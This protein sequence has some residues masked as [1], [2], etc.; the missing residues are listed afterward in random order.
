MVRATSFLFLSI[1]LFDI[2]CVLNVCTALDVGVYKPLPDAG[3]PAQT[4]LQG[5]NSQ[6]VRAEYI[7]QFLLTHSFYLY[8]RMP[9]LYGNHEARSNQTSTDLC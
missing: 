6:P 1:G 2:A 4:L 3:S 7:N 5:I 9:Y 8:A